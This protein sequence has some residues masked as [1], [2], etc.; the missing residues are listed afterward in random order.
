MSV[1]GRIFE[2]VTG[3]IAY[4]HG[5]RSDAAKFASKVKKGQ[6]YYAVITVYS[7]WI[8]DPKYKKGRLLREYRWDGSRSPITGNPMFDHRSAAGVY[9]TEGPLYDNRNNAAC[10]GVLTE[11]EYEEHLEKEAARNR[12]V[13]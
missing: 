6:V 1:L 9:L 12:P 2:G 10:S 3:G 13:F 4:T 7:P 11:A 5:A 8:A